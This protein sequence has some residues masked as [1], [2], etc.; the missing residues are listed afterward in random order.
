MTYNGILHSPK[1]EDIL[2]AAAFE[3]GVNVEKTG[4]HRGWKQVKGRLG[5]EQGASRPG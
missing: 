2:E 3:K 4:W 1:K 5:P